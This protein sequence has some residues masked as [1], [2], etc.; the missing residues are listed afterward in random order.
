L[1]PAAFFALQ[2]VRKPGPGIAT[3]HGGGLI[4]SGAPGRDRLPVPAF[5][6]GLTLLDLEGAGEVQTPLH[7]PRGVDLALGDPVFFRHA[8]AGELAEH[9]N[10]YILVQG[11]AIVGR[12]PTY[13]GLGKCFLG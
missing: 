13:R 12:A 10:E 7:V 6:E 3:C 5:P 8:K 9:V 4:A 1:H 11:D 2:V